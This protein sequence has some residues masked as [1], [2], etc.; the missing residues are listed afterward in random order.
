MKAPYTLSNVGATFNSK[1]KAWS[2]PQINPMYN[3]KASLGQ[4]VANC[5]SRA[6]QMVGTICHEDGF[7]MRN[8]EILRDSVRVALNLR[9]LGLQEGDVLGFSAGNTRH[10]APVVFGAML[11]GNPVGSV[12]PS[13]EKTDIKRT[14]K[15]T[16]PKLVVCD[17]TNY[18]HVKQALSELD[19]SS[20][21][22]VFDAAKGSDWKSVTEL[23]KYHPE[24]HSFV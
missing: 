12:D 7:E 5:L 4:L 6:P 17:N 24:E 16:R 18:H 13:F 1:T 3:P 15:I 10:V 14:F 19:N 9:D 8:W 11:N 22:Y 2:A 23:L 21:I 20:S